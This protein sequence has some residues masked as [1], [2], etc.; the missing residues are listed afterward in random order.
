[1]ELMGSLKEAVLWEPLEGRRVHCR[2]CSFHCRI[3]EGKLGHCSVR[4]NVDGKLYSLNYGKVVAGNPD[5]IEKKPLFHFLPGSRSFSIAAVGCNFRCEFCQNWQISQAALETG[6]I[7]GEPLTP[8]QIVEA[9]IRTGCKSVAYTYTEPTIFMELAQECGRAA[10]EQRLANVFVSNGYMTRDA[11][12]FAG[13]WLDGINIDL[14][15]FSDDYYRNLCGAR[16]QPVLD[17]IAYI[18]KNTRI[19]MEITTLLL[20]EQNDSDEELKKLAG[21]LVSEA[22]PDVPWH[23]SRF[24]PQYK[25]T[26]S[27]ATPLETMRRAE[28]IGKA[29]GLRYVYLGN[30]P[31]EKSENTYCYN[32]GRMLIERMGYRIVANQIKNSKCPHCGTEIAGFG[33]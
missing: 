21:F 19:W 20:P 27:E 11:V 9:A 29:A 17:C 1:M 26:E 16:L 7:E 3:A 32:C 10:K 25:Y 24:Y 14:K 13:D 4:K 23:I 30:V 15:A 31:G 2:L 6:R 33:L 28:E 22:G 8:D 5:P 18:A 12:D